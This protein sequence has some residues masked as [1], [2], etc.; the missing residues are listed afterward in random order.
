LDGNPKA[1]V[2]DGD[3][4]GFGSSYKEAISGK[5]VGIFGPSS[6]SGPV[7][8]RGYIALAIE[9]PEGVE[10]GISI[11]VPN[12]ETSL[13]EPWLRQ[14]MVDALGVAFLFPEECFSPEGLVPLAMQRK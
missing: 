9:S 6:Q 3:R 2:L 14:F 10:C 11:D 1:W 8:R 4:I 5:D 7:Q 13:R 12:G